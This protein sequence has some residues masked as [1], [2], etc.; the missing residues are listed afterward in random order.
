MSSGVFLSMIVS[1]MVCLGAWFLSK[2]ALGDR[3]KG[4]PFECGFDP[5]YSARVPFSVR[6]FLL[7][8]IF[9]IFDIE[10]ALL[11][12]FPFVAVKGYS[13]VAIFTMISFLA[14]LGVGL[15]HEW[16]EGSLDWVEAD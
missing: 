13:V 6:F 8:V 15:V 12:P 4:S 14:V 2:R 3:E 16:H 11:L 7:A 1:V 5:K 10:I 9:L